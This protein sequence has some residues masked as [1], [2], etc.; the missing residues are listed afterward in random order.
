MKKDYSIIDDKNIKGF[1]GKYRWLSNFYVAPCYYQGI[2]YPS[3]ENAYQAS[4]VI[5]EDRNNFLTITPSQSKK[6]W[7]KYTKLDR[8]DVE[9]DGRKLDVMKVIVFDK[10]LRNKELLVKLINTGDK[11]LEETNDW[12]DQFYG[13]DIQD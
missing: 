6:A 9:W 5:T 1:F 2:L 13:V 3:S 12:G 4:K 10:F 11:Y 7:K 8:D